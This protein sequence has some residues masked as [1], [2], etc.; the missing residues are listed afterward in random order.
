MAA[1]NEVPLTHWLCQQNKASHASSE[2]YQRQNELC[3]Q[4]GIDIT[5]HHM[6]ID[7]VL[8]WNY[9]AHMQGL[10]SERKLEI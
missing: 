8:Y 6:I 9:E 10:I 4:S 2:Q 7:Q 5:I 3:G 1:S